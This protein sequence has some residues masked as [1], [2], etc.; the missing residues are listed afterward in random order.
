MTNENKQSVISEFSDSELMM[1]Y[2]NGE[3]DAFC[4]IVTRYK[5]ILYTFLRRF[6]NRQEV[7]EDIFQETFLQLYIT[8]DRFDTNRPLRPW[9]F[10]L[11]A[12]KAKDTLR[13]MRRQSTVNMGALADASDVSIDEIA[14]ILNSYETTP[15][16]EVSWNETAQQVRQVI[17]EMPENGR[18]MLVLAY[19]E[20]LSYRHMAEV[21]SIPIGTVKSRLHAAIVH[22]TRKWKASEGY[23]RPAC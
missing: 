7:V 15:D 14:N 23:L 1:R 18:R 6:S 4:E 19:Y 2:R 3:E 17:L 12:N 16:Q 10:T 5:N 21:L 8:Q 22:F 13:K 20:H 11:A 9:L